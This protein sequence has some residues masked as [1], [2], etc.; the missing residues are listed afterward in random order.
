M[1]SSMSGGGAMLFSSSF[2]IAKQP[3]KVGRACAAVLH[4]APH[5][6]AAVGLEIT[7]LAHYQVLLRLLLQRLLVATLAHVVW[8]AVGR[9]ARDLA[10]VVI[11]SRLD[12]DA[13][14]VGRHS[15]VPLLRVNGSGAGYGRIGLVRRLLRRLQLLG[16]GATLAERLGALL[17]R[18]GQQAPVV[19][20]AG[21]D[22]HAHILRAGHGLRLLLP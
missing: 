8:A 1:H 19:R 9:P 20:R 4:G 11:R 2:G 5:A 22:A 3:V 17:R 16:V 7:G 10:P 13:A 6:D 15:V 12:A 14:A 21:S 18:A